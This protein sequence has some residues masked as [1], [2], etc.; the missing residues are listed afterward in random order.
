VATAGAAVS[1]TVAQ[2]STNGKAND[3]YWPAF[4][5]WAG[6]VLATVVAAA[7]PAGALFRSRTKVR[8][9][10]IAYKWDLVAV[11]GLTV[12]ALIPRVVNLSSEPSPISG[13]E[14]SLAIGAASVLAGTSKNMFISGVQGHATMQYFVLAADFKVLGA[15][16]VDARLLS[17]LAGT[18]TIPLFYLLLRQMFGRGVAILGAVY[19]VAYHFHLQ[20][21]R[22]A[23]ENISDP[24]LLV[25]AL[26]FA[27]RASEKGKA[28]DFAL[29]GLV[30]GLGLYLSPA[31]RIVPVIVA[32]FFA[33]TVLRRPA[34]LRQAVPGVGLIA[35][36]YSIAALPVGV[37]W[38]THPNEFMD[39]IN[40]VGIFQSGWLDAHRAATGESTLAVLWDQTVRSFGGF[41]RY[42]DTSAQYYVPISLVDRLSLVPFLLGI[43]YSV[44]RIFDRRHFVLLAAFAAVVITGGVLTK[45]PP[46]SQRLM[47]TAPAVAAFVAIGVKLIADAASKWRAKAGTV[48]AGIGI[49]ALV[50]VN[51][52]FYFFDYRTGGYYSDYNTRVGTQVAEYVKTLPPNTRVF[53]YGAP[54]M[55]ISTIGH[56]AMVF[57]LRDWARFDVLKDG[58]MTP[59]AVPEGEA[60]AVFIFLPHRW[61]QEMSPLMQS[62]PGGEVKAFTTPAGRAGS[63]GLLPEQTSFL[64]YEVLTANSCIPVTALT[65]TPAPMPAG[66]VVQPTVSPG[67]DERNGQRIKDLMMLS[68][69]LQ[70]F[71]GGDNSYPSTGGSLQTLCAAEQVDAGCKLKGAG[72]TL[73]ADPLGSPLANGYW[74][75]SD[76][77][78]FTLVAMWEGTTPP[79]AGLPCPATLTTVA[80]H[81]SLFCMQGKP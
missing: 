79:P 16:L 13:D 3:S 1:F 32:A 63:D 12:A 35:L 66:E 53:F 73:P 74:Y 29:T 75:I 19:L 67:A 14:A 61:N 62:C 58:R 81:S 72:V 69:R 71:F 10:L 27:W 8:E 60:P 80:G 56:P 52:H 42:A 20:F 55:Y 25:A 4:G 37:F 22:V 24:L 7:A 6:A 36:T 44:F 51:M 65:P 50:A 34:F 68:Q 5:L 64:A 70:G 48:L 23:L 28:V 18:V 21:S 31:G 39:R 26:L 11:G 47:G 57:P 17:A 76:G 43:G 46:A 15:S 40:V 78:T 41:G 33:Y 59:S 77:S 30:M 2:I 45:D 9:W 49:A 54:R 38:L